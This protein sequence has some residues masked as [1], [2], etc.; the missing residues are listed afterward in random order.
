MTNRC[1]SLI[2][3]SLFTLGSVPLFA[4]S[5]GVY[6]PSRKSKGVQVFEAKENADGIELTANETIDL[7]FEVNVM[8]KHPTLPILYAGGFNSN[9]GIVPGASIKVDKRGKYISH[10]RIDL[11]HRFC[12][13]SFDRTNR[14]LLGADYG[15]GFVD[16]YKV[17]EGGHVGKRVSALDEGRKNAHC[18]WPTRDN[19]FVYIP[20]VKETNGLFQYRF[21]EKS[22]SLT[23]LSPKNANPPA[24]TGPRH[25]AYH[26]KLPV[27]Y[28]SNEQ[29][30]GVS[31]YDIEESGQLKIRQVCDAVDPERAKDGLSSSDIT[32]SPNGRYL[33]SGIRGHK[34]D[35]D[36]VSRYKINPD[37]SVTHLGLTKADKIPWGFTFS[38]TGRY[39]FVTAFQGGS[40]TAY[41]VL[42]GGDLKQAARVACDENIM[43]VITTGP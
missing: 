43:D 14:F 26:H 40:L 37:G 8:V 24:G 21:D 36:W 33:F 2:V 17:D 11:H 23:P 38:P 30:L 34:H 25:L 10:E 22:G 16:V 18:V 13:L 12:F 42:E 35:F 19:R 20:Y 6:L 4:Q 7:G 41:E 5:Y 39:L 3:F 31:V 28:F 32:I 15:G 9:E 1:R 29:H 27:V